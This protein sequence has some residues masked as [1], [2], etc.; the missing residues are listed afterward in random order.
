MSVES[1]SIVTP[2]SALPLIV[3][4]SGVPLGNRARYALAARM[5]TLA[6]DLSH[7][8][9]DVLLVAPNGT[10]ITGPGAA[11]TGRSI[12][13]LDRPNPNRYE[14][15]ST[16]LGDALKVF[17]RAL[18]ALRPDK[19]TRPVVLLSTGVWVPFFAR[20]LVAL[21]E[22]MY[23]HLDVPGIPHTELALSR[24]RFWR[25]KV[26]LY[27][28][29]FSTLLRHSAVI[30]TINE[31]HARFLRDH[32]GIDAL[33]VPDLLNEGWLRRLM[34]L[35][36]H[37]PGDRVNILYAGALFGSRIDLFLKTVAPL[38]EQGTVR[39]V[40]L[41]DGP[42]RARLRAQFERSGILF[43]GYEPTDSLLARLAEADI[44]YSDV[45]H[46]IGTPYKVLE[47]MA[48]G[49]AVL[50]HDTDS[51]RGTITNGVDGVLCGKDERSVAQA[52]R[53]LIEDGDLRLRL[54]QRA[55]RRILE[56][57][58]SDRLQGLPAKYSEL[59]TGV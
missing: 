37:V 20:M 15:V 29:V 38:A 50:S 53:M 47:Y 2:A 55:R 7:A 41:G 42:D 23:L 58:Q 16:V 46:E 3:V 39:T 14:T 6:S 10:R 1:A 30:T 59:G 35:P 22:R 25:G 45:W 51:L 18:V 40:V 13:S 31:S 48:A 33:V 56:L 8:G 19:Q 27:A 9:F 36:A 43:P 32:F 12:R 49:R 21:H 5:N 34:S 24:P 57:H 54:G 44:C 17:V 11:R 26:G 52:L 4:M 28:H